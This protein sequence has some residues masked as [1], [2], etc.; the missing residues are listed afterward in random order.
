MRVGQFDIIVSQNHLNYAEMLL[1][2][3]DNF[4]IIVVVVIKRIED[5]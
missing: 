3:D 5:L 4:I 1:H 2:I